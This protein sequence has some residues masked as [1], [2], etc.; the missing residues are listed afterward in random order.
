MRMQSF[1]HTGS[2]FWGGPSYIWIMGKY[3]EIL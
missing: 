3:K 2:Q 1:I